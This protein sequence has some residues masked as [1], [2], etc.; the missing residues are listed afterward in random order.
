MPKCALCESTQPLGDTCDV[1][2]RPFPAAEAVPVLIQPLPG[3][4]ATMHEAA[5]GEARVER[6]ADLVP[7]AESDGGFAVP[8]ERIEGFFPTAAEPVSVEV[9]PLEVERVGDEA[10]LDGALDPAP[11]RVS[12]RYCRT[13]ATAGERICAV[14]GMR[15]PLVRPPPAAAA[16]GAAPCR[17]CG[18]P[19][20]GTQCPACG[21]RGGPVR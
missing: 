14:C 18:L 12:C 9:T 15:L 19:M 16:G 7:T 6:L 4:E 10:V 2:G 11:T 17:D 13:P 20:T 1:C 3:L 21:A 8:G 5:W